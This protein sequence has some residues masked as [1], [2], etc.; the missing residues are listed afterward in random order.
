M[1]RKTT[2]R[3][4]ACLMVLILTATLFTGCGKDGTGV[5]DPGTQKPDGQ[6]VIEE[7]REGVAMGRFV[8]KEMDLGDNSLTDWNSRL[9]RQSDGSFLLADNSGFVLR[10]RDNGASWVKED[11]AWLTRMKEENKYILTMAFGPDQTAAVIW[12]EPEEGSGDEGN[13]VQLKMDMQLTI[14]KPD[15]TEIPVKMNLEADDLWVN[16]VS[17]SDEGRIIVSTLVP[18]CMK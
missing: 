10:S 2:K 1:R 8:E 7:E 16:S 5:T 17:I 13:G 18:T 4:A 11:L 6:S 14:I 15:N 9:F 12:T 3:L